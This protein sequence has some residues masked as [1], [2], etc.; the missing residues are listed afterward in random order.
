MP[1]AQSKALAARAGRS[2]IAPIKMT[3]PSERAKAQEG[4]LV[5]VRRSEDEDGSR[6]VGYPRALTVLAKNGQ[7]QPARSLY[8][9]VQ[10]NVIEI[11][12]AKIHHDLHGEPPSEE[13]NYK[14]AWECA[15]DV[16]AKSVGVKGWGPIDSF[17]SGIPPVFAGLIIEQRRNEESAMRMLRVIARRVRVPDDC[18]R[19]IEAFVGLLPARDAI[20]CRREQ[21]PA[22]MQRLYEVHM[23]EVGCS[24]SRFDNVSLQSGHAG[25]AEVWTGSF[26]D[27]Y[28]SGNWTLFPRKL[29]PQYHELPASL[30]VNTN[31]DYENP[32]GW[33]EGCVDEC[34][35]EAPGHKTFWFGEYDDEDGQPGYINCYRRTFPWFE[36]RPWDFYLQ[37]SNAWP[38]GTSI[39]DDPKPHPRD[40]PDSDANSDSDSDS[41][42]GSD[43]MKNLHKKE[44]TRKR[45]RR[46][47]ELLL[48][49]GYGVRWS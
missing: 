33:P 24:G 30:G 8:E 42:P 48:H 14:E 9:Y 35:P 41:G 13:H 47:A 5:S 6:G 18:V 29:L 25:S 49:Y 45:S 10:P 16:Y 28:S 46:N 38:A 43:Y 39:E 26:G 1:T 31:G 37:P 32:A 36:E 11:C 7:W 12:A 17:L 21:L 23:D 3:L 15:S 20:P 40:K 27:E 4:G 22:L 34:A 19:H 44:R 2:F